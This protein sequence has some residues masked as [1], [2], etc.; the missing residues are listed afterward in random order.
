MAGAFEPE[1][2]QVTSNT[3][4]SQIRAL[5]PSVSG[6]GSRL[7]AQNVI[8][9]VVDLTPTAE[10][11]VL[12]TDLQTA[13]AFGSQTAFKVS[14]TTTTLISNPGFYRVFGTASGFTNTPANESEFILSDGVTDKVIWSINSTSA[15]S[16]PGAGPFA[17][18]DFICFIGL[19]ES[20]KGKT[21]SANFFLGGSTRQIADSN[22][23]FVS[24]SGFTPL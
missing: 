12:R 3:L 13:L 19:D 7:G 23:E 8:V 24:P 18:F 10:G 2:A 5:L 15:P 4:E 22:G 11:S 17:P 6:F 21:D 14:N 16:A 9:P 1:L 20:L